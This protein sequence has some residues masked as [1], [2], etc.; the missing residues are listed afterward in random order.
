M[1]TAVAPRRAPGGSVSAVAILSSEEARTAIAPMLPEGVTLERVAREVQLAAMDNPD[2]L[3]CAPDTIIA[4][5]CK[6]V[7]WGLVIGETVHLVPVGGKLKAWQDYK[8]KIELMVR[9][10]AARLV[11]AQ[12]VYEHEPFEYELG[13]HPRILHHP[14]LSLRDRGALIG[15]YAYAKL[16]QYDFKAVVLST[17]EI[18]QI[19]RKS[20]RSWKNGPLSDIPWYALKTAIHRL[21]KQIPRSEALARALAEDDEDTDDLLVDAA[22]ERPALAI[23]PPVGSSPGTEAN[24]L[25]AS[26]WP[27]DVGEEK[28]P[29]ADVAPAMTL[30]QALN[31]KL[32]G[33]PQKWGGKGGQS[34]S[35][36]P[37][38]MLKG[39]PKW[40]RTKIDEEAAEGRV[41]DTKVQL[42]AA[43]ELV[44]AHKRAEADQHQPALP[45]AGESA[46]A[47]SGGPAPM[48]KAG[49]VGDALA[50][51]GGAA[52]SDDGVRITQL[53]REITALLKDPHLTPKQREEFQADSQQANTLGELQALVESLKTAILGF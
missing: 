4:A 39:I 15:A 44:V 5:V 11:D 32:P 27:E 37:L 13:L 53:T 6:A 41:D 48:P 50:A 18:D 52:A 46:P 36:L 45:L 22:P 34:L 16:N 35:V 25:D 38:S 26:D 14:I 12:C 31:M 23:A 8:G 29:A 24:P 42:L 7:S 1:S 3:T 30:E 33:G 9:H 21:A 51:H 47:G 2:I 40:L 19:R 28:A 10:R 20:S 49:K 17:E 43:A